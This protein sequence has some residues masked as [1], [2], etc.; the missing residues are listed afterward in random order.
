MENS[1]YYLV[2]KAQN[3]CYLLIIYI[4]IIHIY[5]YIKYLELDSHCTS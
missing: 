1:T 3:T 5:I 4:N 2:W